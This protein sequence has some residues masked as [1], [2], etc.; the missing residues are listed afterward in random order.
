[1]MPAAVWPDQETIL[2]SADPQRLQ[3]LAALIV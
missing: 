3:V 2:A 1:M